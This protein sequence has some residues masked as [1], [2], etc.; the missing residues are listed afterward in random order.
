MFLDSN[1]S[2]CDQK[3]EH[4]GADHGVKGAELKLAVVNRR[5]DID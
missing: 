5:A 3:G 4:G 2:Q 1:L